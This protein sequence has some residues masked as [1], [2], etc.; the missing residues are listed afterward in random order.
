MVAEKELCLHRLFHILSRKEGYIF[1]KA[2]NEN[3]KELKMP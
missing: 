2:K 3:K 1:Y